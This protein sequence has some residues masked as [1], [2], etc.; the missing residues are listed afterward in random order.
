V[1]T[2]VLTAPPRPP[3]RS[4]P[5]TAHVHER[6]P[7]PQQQ[8]HRSSSPTQAAAA[9]AAAATALHRQC[10]PGQRG[11]KRGGQQPSSLLALLSHLHLSLRGQAGCANSYNT[12]SLSQAIPDVHLKFNPFHTACRPRDA[13]TTAHSPPPS[14]P[15]PLPCIAP[16]SQVCITASYLQGLPA[17]VHLLLCVIQLLPHAAC[18][19][20]LAGEGL[21]LL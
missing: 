4:A 1:L 18:L 10:R 8:Q 19:L 12:T 16:M 13:I 7:A 15:P 14:P 20:V 17:A 11:V 21:A 2:C 6:P 5:L 9:A 3:W